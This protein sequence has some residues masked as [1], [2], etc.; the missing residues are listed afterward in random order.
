MTGIT[1]VPGA[2]TAGASE[3]NAIEKALRSHGW[4]RTAAARALRIN[5]TTL[6]RRMKK[7]SLIPGEPT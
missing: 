7:H 4:N 6:W 3:R 1:K 2:D 5:R